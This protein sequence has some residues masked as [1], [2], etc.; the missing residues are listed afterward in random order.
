LKAAVE[1]YAEYRRRLRQARTQ[2]PSDSPLART[3]DD[4]KDVL[5]ATFR[6]D[7]DQVI[8]WDVALPELEAQLVSAAPPVTAPANSAGVTFTTP[9][10]VLRD[11]PDPPPL[12]PEAVIGS[13]DARPPWTAEQGVFRGGKFT[14]LEAAIGAINLIIVA[15]SGLSGLYF[16]NSTFGSFA[17]YLTLALWGSTATAGLALLRRLVPGALTTS[18]PGLGG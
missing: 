9:P 13:A 14:A 1:H 18:Q 11:V 2:A 17:D 5:D 16:A 4:H 12:N 3:L 7:A 6:G 15:A 8:W 10:T